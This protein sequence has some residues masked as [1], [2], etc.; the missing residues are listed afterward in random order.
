MKAWAA[1]GLR[2]VRAAQRVV[3]V[4]KGVGMCGVMW[5]GVKGCF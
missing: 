1:R 3:G 4:E 5:M 2:D